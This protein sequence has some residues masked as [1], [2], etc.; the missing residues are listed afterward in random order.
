MLRPAT[1][2]RTEPAIAEGPVA[3]I[4]VGSNSIRLVVYE[5]LA[6]A[7]A[8][9]HNEKVTCGLGRTLAST[10][11]LDPKGIACAFANLPRFVALCRG[12]NVARLDMLATAAVRDAADG[13]E[14]AAT[15]SR[16][17]GVPLRVLSG[18]EEARLGALGVIAGNPDARGVMG[19]LGGSSLELI[20]LENG[21]PGPSLTLPLGPL[22][23]IEQSG[24][25]PAE[26]AKV[27]KERFRTP[28]WLP[29]V[30]H[31]DLFA[32]GGAWRA[33]A[34][35][36]M[37]R[38]Q[39]PLPVIHNYV[40]EAEEARELAAVAARLDPSGKVPGLSRARLRVM[41]FA[42][43]LMKRVLTAVNPDRV[44]FSAF[45]LREGQIFDLLPES[46]RAR[47]PLIAAC[48]DLAARSSPFG[49][50]GPALLAWTAPLFPGETPAASRLRLAA[51]ILADVARREH[52]DV[53]AALAFERGLYI[54]AV[55]ITHGERAYLALALFARY[56]GDIQSNLTQRVRGLIP[57][58]DRER[59]V[60]L[61]RALRLA[62]SV[63]GGVP[64]LLAKTRLEV[65]RKTLTLRLGSGG[66]NLDGEMVVKM[67]TPVAEILGRRPEVA[68][69]TR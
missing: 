21:A 50:E 15:L 58:K 53:R 11:R 56:K 62:H 67:L 26:A 8:T 63:A 10:G 44:I 17:L 41:P 28:D 30:K 65:G 3:V 57:A 42:A 20:A 4:D 32:V 69:G 6:R 2:Q 9:V 43:V 37:A 27:A 39:Y 23:L 52:P 36:N 34:K 55:G 25:D 19:D 13:P 49:L 66:A 12:M 40:L 7:T 60:L 29:R 22:Q 16:N 24:G 54:P 51:A 31:R 64:K 1:D 38:T 61:G 47:D 46:E 5:R 14:F 18:E 45:G 35:F 33:L 68:R 59:A 48:E